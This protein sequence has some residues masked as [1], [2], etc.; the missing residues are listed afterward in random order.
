MPLVE[1]VQLLVS[2]K[3]MLEK[4]SNCYDRTYQRHVKLKVKAKGCA[5]RMVLLVPEFPFRSFIFKILMWPSPLINSILSK[6]E[7]KFLCN[8]IEWNLLKVT[9]L[10]YYW[11]TLSKQVKAHSISC[12]I[13]L[14]LK[15]LPFFTRYF[16][17]KLIVIVWSALVWSCNFGNVIPFLTGLLLLI[18]DRLNQV[19]DK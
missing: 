2:S 11:A 10:L 17:S 1:Q 3:Q 8:Q 14:F 18:F 13:L 16:C 7:G 9:Q 19:Q 6:A 12:K 5:Y 15:K 4:I